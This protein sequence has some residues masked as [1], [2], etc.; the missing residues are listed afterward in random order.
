M[1]HPEVPESLDSWKIL[2]R[3]FRFRHR[4]WSRVSP[5]ERLE[6]EME[7]VK[8]FRD[9][10]ADR[11][12]DCGLAQILGHKGDLMLTHYA[13]S[14]D[15]LGEVQTHVERLR[16]ADYLETQASYV[17]ILELGL[18]E[19]TGRIHAELRKRDHKPH[20]EEWNGAFD[21]LLAEEEK[22]PRNAARLWAKIPRRRYV[23]FYPMDKKRGETVNWYTL[24]F[25]ERAKL[26]VEH[27][28]VGRSFHG[29]VTQ[30]ISGSIG[31]DDW[32]WGVDLYADDPL[33]FKKLIYEMRFDEASAKYAA[34]GKFYTGMQFSA[35]ELPRFLNGDGSPRLLESDVSTEAALR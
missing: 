8:V 3:M 34:F 16:L 4:A 18:Y 13:K 31:F 9:L 22:N 21:A 26:M 20:S 24:P 11:D 12:G 6:I 5:S 19:A 10:A 33:I 17:S 1:R 25:E 23:C 2:H 32:E 30:V 15:A 29:L 14:F 7:A 35:V 28:K 27:G